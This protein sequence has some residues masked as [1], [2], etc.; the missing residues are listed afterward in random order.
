MKK[1]K[2]KK[3]FVFGF[4]NP[5]MLILMG[6]VV[7]FLILSFL[8]VAFFIKANAFVLLGVFLAV[9][10]GIGMLMKFSPQIGFGLVVLGIALL[11][12][13]MLFNE[14]GGITLASML[15]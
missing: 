6:V 7:L 4:T 15:S 8:G 13:P 9:I 3:G 2:N 12:L 5:I 11:L 1:L 10:G 14:L